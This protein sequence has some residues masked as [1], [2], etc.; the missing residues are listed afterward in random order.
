MYIPKITTVT[1]LVQPLI[2]APPTY[3]FVYKGRIQSITVSHQRNNVR[4]PEPVHKHGITTYIVA[5][6]D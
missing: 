4:V 1:D 3:I 2:Q 6:V 5:N